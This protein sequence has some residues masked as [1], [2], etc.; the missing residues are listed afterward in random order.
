MALDPHPR[1]IS[2]QA[3]GEGTARK[4]RVWIGEQEISQYIVKVIIEAG[5][6]DA[7]IVTLVCLA[8]VVTVETPGP[9]KEKIP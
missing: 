3:S 2:V 7:T 1:F 5:I 4:W 8:N 6:K 9:L